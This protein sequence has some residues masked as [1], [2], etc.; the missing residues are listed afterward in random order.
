MSQ[1][2]QILTP[3]G[4]LVQGDCWEPQDKDAENNPLLIRTGPNAG[5]PRVLY[6]LAIAIPK[7]DPGW[8]DIWGKIHAEAVRSFPDLFNAGVCTNPSFAFKLTDGDSIVGNRKGKRPCDNEGFPGNWIL[9]FSGSFA[10]SVFQRGGQELVT[11]QDAVKRGY[12]IRILGNVAGNNSTQMP[13]VFL[14]PVNV[15]FIGYGEEIVVGP[16][17]SAFTENPTGAL[18]V[19]ASATP[20]A[21]AAAAPV[22][23]AA[24]APVTPPAAA[25]PTGQVPAPPVTTGQVPA[26][27]VTTGVVPAPDFLTPPP[28]GTPP[29]PVGQAPMAPPATSYTI[30]GDQSSTRWTKEQLLAAGHTE[31]QISGYIPF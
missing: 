18:P 4:R 12:Y 30:T 14:N 26:P 22:P 16:D 19:G 2:T 9:H 31:A 23:P 17:G 25:A 21:P 10:P 7:T 28:P 24:A 27:S 5:Q 20:L 8:N 13:G 29:A 1:N 3:V 15:E 11:S 6:Y